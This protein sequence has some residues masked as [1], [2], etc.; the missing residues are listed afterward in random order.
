MLADVDVAHHLPVAPLEIP[1]HG[2]GLAHAAVLEHRLLQVEDKALGA[3]QG[4]PGQVGL[5]QAAVT[6][7]GAVVTDRV[8]GGGKLAVVIKAAAAQYLASNVG[9][10]EKLDAETV[11][12][13]AATVD[14]QVLAPPVW[15][16]LKGNAASVVDLANSVRAAT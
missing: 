8:T 1:E 9:I 5:L 2:Q 3:L 14:R 16:A 13:V 6:E 15:F 11:E 10:A 12:I 7:R 4:L